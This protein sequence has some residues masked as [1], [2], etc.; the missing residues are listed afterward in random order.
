M[1]TICWAAKGG[2][3]TTVVAA[4]RALAAR[5]PSLVVDLAGDMPLVFGVAE[6][7]G[8]GVHD[9]L[10]SEAAPERLADL[11]LSVAPNRRLLPAG[12]SEPPIEARWNELATQLRDDPRDVVIDAGTST[13]RPELVAVAD[14]AWIV[15]RACYLAL[16]AAARQPCRPNGIVLV[17]EPGRALRATDI[18]AALG[19][20][21]V[22]EVPL[23][24]AIARAVDAGLL[25]A[26]LPGPFRNQLREAA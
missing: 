4:T 8:P 22:A 17:D 1:I 3:G 10:T 11:E 18:E 12:R 26:R 14:H 19:A 23:D 9:W 25:V 24:P 7:D 5:D 21:V 16:C 15:T 20:P 2:S 6:P 13:P